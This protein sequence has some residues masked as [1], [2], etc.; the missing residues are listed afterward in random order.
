MSTRTAA[1]LAWSLLGLTVL[2]CVLGG[3]LLLLNGRS[4]AVFTLAF[5]AFP[6]V[7]TVIAARHPHNPIGWLFVLIGL[8]NM[9]RFFT[10]EYAVY[11]LVTRPGALPGGVWLAW[12]GAWTA[13]ATWTSLFFTLLLFPTGRLLSPRWRPVAWLVGV[14]FGLFTVL[15][16][17][18]PG[19]MAD[20]P[21]PNPTG[22][23]LAAGTLLLIHTILDPVSAGLLLI[24]AAAV[25]M[26]FRRAQGEERQQLK[27]FAY[28]VSCFIGV[29]VVSALTQSVVGHVPLIDLA[30]LVVTAVALTAIPLAIGVAILRYRLYAIDMLIRRTLIYSLLTG[31]LLAVYFGSVVLLQAGFRA[32]TGQTNELAIIISTLVSAALFQPLRQGLQHGIERHFYRRTYDATT[33]LAAFS[34]H[35]RDEV[36]LPTLRTELVAV[37]Q[38]TMQPASISLWVRPAAVPPRPDY[39]SDGE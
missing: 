3:L 30:G 10:G 36:D 5:L 18:K 17:I 34:T 27:W 33:T 31:L 22:L 11:S 14:V 26:R 4:P 21:V 20:V 32:L 9:L 6:L 23:E 8:A 24:V 16:I 19:P 37:V 29:S 7:G 1:R 28:A 25:L 2:L 38:E 15:D 12:S 39:R 13:A 35:L